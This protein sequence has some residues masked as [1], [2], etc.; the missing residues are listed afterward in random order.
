M[1]KATI[2]VAPATLPAQVPPAVELLLLRK[3]GED[4]VFC[5]PE[6][7]MEEG[8]IV[9]HNDCLSGAQLIAFVCRVRPI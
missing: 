3:R 2:D 8:D 9:L 7:L 4:G 6:I 5:E 1:I